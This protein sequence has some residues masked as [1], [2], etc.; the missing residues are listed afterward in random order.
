MTG[1]GEIQG[2]SSIYYSLDKAFQNVPVEDD[3]L[4]F[5]SGIPQNLWRGSIIILGG[6][7]RNKVMLDMINRFLR[8]RILR[9]QFI[10][11]M[12]SKKWNE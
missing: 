8:V 2:L 3:V 5:G 4:F 10:S 12:N 6:D 9:C 7:D 1:F 11:K